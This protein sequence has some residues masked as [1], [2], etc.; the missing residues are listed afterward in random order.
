MTPEQEAKCREAMATLTKVAAN[1]VNGEGFTSYYAEDYVKKAPAWLLKL[2][3]R[4]SEKRHGL[5]RDIAK[6]LDCLRPVFS[7]QGS[8]AQPKVDAHP[9]VIARVDILREWLED[10]AREA[11]HNEPGAGLR[12]D[13]TLAD[14]FRAIAA[15][16][17]TPPTQPT[18]P[19]G[20]EGGE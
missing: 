2:I 9:A 20:Q 11:E 6:A 14:A 13:Y 4:D 5:G 1:L 8:A 15:S 18:Q 19:S 3:R 7:A 12:A 10:S 17:P 16:L